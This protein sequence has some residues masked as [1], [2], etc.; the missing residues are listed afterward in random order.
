MAT[1]IK[2][3]SSK[4]KAIMTIPG[5]KNG[6]KGLKGLKGR[7]VKAAA[8]VFPGQQNFTKNKKAKADKKN[9]WMKRVGGK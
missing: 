3:K 6:K 2:K 4:K 9:A 1:K 7:G 5:K 8:Q